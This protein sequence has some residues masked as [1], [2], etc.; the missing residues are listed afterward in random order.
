[1]ELDEAEV[2]DGCTT[3]EEN[4]D[5]TPTD[6]QEEQTDSNDPKI[7]GNITIDKEEGG[8]ALVFWAFPLFLLRRNSRTS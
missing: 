1:M 6:E 5:E 8:C 3:E 2:W 7:E 4:G